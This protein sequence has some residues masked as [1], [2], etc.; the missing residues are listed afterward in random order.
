MLFWVLLCAWA[1]G[2]VSGTPSGWD[3]NITKR[4]IKSPHPSK[5]NYY[6][7]LTQCEPGGRNWTVAVESEKGLGKSY[8]GPA[9][10]SFPI[11]QSGPMTLLW[12]EH[13]DQSGATNW[14][15]NLKTDFVEH[16]HPGGAGY[17]TWYAVMDHTGHNGGPLPRPNQVHFSAR[18]HINDFVIDG[19][20]RAFLG[21][22]GWWDG[23]AYMIEVNFHLNKWGDAHSDKDIIVIHETE[24]FKFVCM[25]GSAMGI[26]APRKKKAEVSVAWS[27]IIES[28]VKRGIFPAPSEGWADAET[29]TVFI[30]TEVRN[31]TPTNSV[32]ADLW[33]TNLRVEKIVLPVSDRPTE[34]TVD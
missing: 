8:P 6:E 30:G 7:D 11:N 1:R 25:D 9:N 5:D 19:E 20:T 10:Q 21:W 28:L 2:E 14:S 27:P 15:V 26:S 34:L 32:L 29:Q 13:V 22:Q 17:F 4:C 33:F 31:N 18:V 23:K 24:S 12:R 16:A 3:Y